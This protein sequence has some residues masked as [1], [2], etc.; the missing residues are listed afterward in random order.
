MS[1]A[2]ELG[3]GFDADAV[4]RVV[5]VLD[6][7]QPRP[8]TTRG[9][10]APDISAMRF[11]DFTLVTGMMPGITGVV[12]PSSSRSSRKSNQ[13][14]ASKKNCDDAEVGVR[15]LLGLTA[16]V[17]GALGRRR[18]T[19]GVH[20]DTDGEVADLAHEL[21]ELGRVLQVARRE[22]QVLGRVAAEREDVL[23]AR[24]AYRVRMS[25]S[26]ARLCAAQVRCAIARHRRLRLIHTTRSCV[27]SRVEPP[28]PYVTD[29]NDGL[30]RL[31]VAER[32]LELGL[33]RRRLRR[34][35]LEGVRRALGDDVGDTH[36]HE[37]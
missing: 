19:F 24:V 29:T 18:M 36:G 27:R 37:A 3:R 31:Q 11:T 4:H 28:A 7:A 5:V 13:T 9:K 14:S 22:V 8:P 23:H 35:E 30:Q 21:D 17:L 1:V 32:L 6:R 26:S 2:A 12:T 34:E 10:S 25:S 20:G 15:E 16:P 33:G